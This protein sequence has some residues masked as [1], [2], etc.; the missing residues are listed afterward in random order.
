MKQSRSPKAVSVIAKATGRDK[1][2]AGAFMTVGDGAVSWREQDGGSFVSAV[3][4]NGKVAFKGPGGTW[5]TVAPAG[6]CA[7]PQPRWGRRGCSRWR[8]WTTRSRCRG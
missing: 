7:R 4:A 5:L 2:P 6:G 1:T 3:R 8:S